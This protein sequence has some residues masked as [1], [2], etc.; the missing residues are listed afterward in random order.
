M[1]HVGLSADSCCRLG[2]QHCPTCCFALATSCLRLR[3]FFANL[4]SARAKQ[5]VVR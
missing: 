4:W 5:H 3:G 2:V 1:S